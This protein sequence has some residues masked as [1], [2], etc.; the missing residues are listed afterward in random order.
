LEGFAQ[1]YTDLAEQI[2]AR[3]EGRRPDSN[4]LLVPGISDG[5]DGV[6]FIQAVLESAEHGSAWTKV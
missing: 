3:K 4:A 2:V 6:K 5:V 1:L